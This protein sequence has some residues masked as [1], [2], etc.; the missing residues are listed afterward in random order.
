MERS[1]KLDLFGD[2]PWMDEPDQLDFESHGFACMVRRNMSTGV[3]CGYVALPDGHALRDVPEEALRDELFVHGGITLVG[4]LQDDPT[5][6]YW[7]GFDAAHG[8][9]YSPIWGRYGKPE[10]ELLETYRTVAYMSGECVQ[11]AAQLAAVPAAN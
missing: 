3:L 5:D 2:G 6:S 9:D 7:L 8:C 11:L 10:P 4:G 1:E